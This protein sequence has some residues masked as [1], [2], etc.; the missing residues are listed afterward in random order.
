M[1]TKLKNLVVERIDLCDFGANID[2]RTGDGA[3]ILLYKRAPE[4]EL[5][6]P[7]QV[8]DVQKH[9]DTFD[10]TMMLGIL[11]SHAADVRKADP[12]LTIE[13]SFAK[14]CE[15]HPADYGLYVQALRHGHT[16]APAA[17]TA[18][19][20]ELGLVAD[21]IGKRYAPATHALF[22]TARQLVEKGAEKTLEQ[23]ISKVA[24]DPQHAAL[25]ASYDDERRS[26]TK[27][28]GS[29][30]ARLAA[31]LAALTRERQ[32]ELLRELAQS[33]PELFLDLLNE[34]SS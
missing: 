4:K 5:I 19:P 8:R 3:H 9:G 14:A 25:H 20:Q 16:S 23:A 7:I 33:E 29:A 34:T 11:E 22:A 15:R 24:Q 17:L 1:P 28:A 12:S 6:M 10:R 32:V 31:R 21:R 2:N 18:T 13:Q 30:K 26:L 27:Q